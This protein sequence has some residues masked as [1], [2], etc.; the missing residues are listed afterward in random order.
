MTIPFAVLA[1]ALSGCT[2]SPKSQET[3]WQPRTSTAITTGEPK[4]EFDSTQ[5]MMKN[6]DQVNELIN[7]RI[8]K[9]GNV[10]ASQ[11]DDAEADSVVV[12]LET[13][14]ALKDAMRIA[15]ARPDRDGTRS[16]L[17]SLVRREL[18]DLNSLDVVLRDLAQESIDALKAKRS[19]KAQATYVY[20]LENLMAELRPDLAND[21]T[22]EIV[23]RIRDARI[24]ID[25]AVRK[26]LMMRTM[27][28]PVSPSDTAERLLSQV[29]AKAS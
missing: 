5:L 7:A 11:V 2:T 22:R 4:L 20:I 8:Q 12:E 13:L 10:Q 21:N 24:D 29:P 28:R 6:S 16:S 23:T 9:A 15:L 1:L 18:V 26:Q 14:E 25:P 3:Q 19:A 27:S 17:Y